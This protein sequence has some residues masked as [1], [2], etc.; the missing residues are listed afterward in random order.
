MKHPGQDSN[1]QLS[2]EK[3]IMLYSGVQGKITDFPAVYF[4]QY[5]G[6]EIGFT[7]LAISTSVIIILPKPNPG[8]IENA[9]FG[10]RGSLLL[11]GDH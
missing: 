10:I 7:L 1:D 4:G 5:W 3:Y 6:K 8:E 9:C 11:A 2:R